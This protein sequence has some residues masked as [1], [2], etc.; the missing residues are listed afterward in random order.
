MEDKV[1]NIAATFYRSLALKD[2][3]LWLSQNKVN[4]LDKFEKAVNHQGMMKSA[5]A[6]PLSSIS[7]ISFN[8]ASK[9]TKL[10]YTNEKGKEKKLNIGF[11][12]KES[13]NQ[14]GEYLGEKLGFSKSATKENQLK[15]FLLDGL[16]LLITIFATFFLGTMEDTSE[17]INSESSRRS[18][19]NGAIVK[20]IVDVVGPTGVFIIGGLFS[21]YFFYNILRRFNNPAN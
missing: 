5:I 4:N 16:Y 19:S 21:V 1:Y 18:R 13:S 12:D 8:E 10:K 3:E 11:D 7:N 6:I 20:L 14:F 9:H 15:P 17:L 2:N